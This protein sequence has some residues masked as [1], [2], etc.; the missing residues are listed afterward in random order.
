MKATGREIINGAAWVAVETWGRHLALFVVFVILARHLGPEAFGFATLAMVVPVIVAVP[1][2]RGIPEA[3]IQR[4]NIE[5]IHFDS[6]FWLLAVTGSALSGLVW[7]FA[8][9]IAAAFSQPVL[10]D[11]V[12]WTS[13]VIVLQALAAVPAAHL[14]RQLHFRLF[15]LR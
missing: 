12:R 4:P 9:A 1:V 2:T 8:G 7:A 5:S 11:L 6:A 13:V 3:L 10:E 14:K 15:A